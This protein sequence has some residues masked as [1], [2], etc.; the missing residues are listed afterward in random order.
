MAK[1]SGNKKRS[2]RR[3]RVSRRGRLSRMNYGKIEFGIEKSDSEREYAKAMRELNLKNF[4]KDKA[5]ANKREYDNLVYAE[6]KAIHRA[7]NL[8]SRIKDK[9]RYLWNSKNKESDY[10]HD[11][12]LLKNKMFEADKKRFFNLSPL[13][14]S[15]HIFKRP[16]IGLKRKIR[17]SKKY[18]EAKE[19]KELCERRCKF[20][21]EFA[22]IGDLAA[23]NDCD[24]FDTVQGRLVGK[25]IDKWEKNE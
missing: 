17:N 10:L 24:F 16:F 3:G 5:E 14:K 6:D 11:M 7:K 12:S 22:R 21:P 9:G 19:G 18:K 15:K 1:K 23:C 2:I 13:G 20:V 25:L 4:E 8:A